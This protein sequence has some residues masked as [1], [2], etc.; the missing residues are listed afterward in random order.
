MPPLTL[1]TQ[2]LAVF[3]FF[4]YVFLSLLLLFIYLSSRS[5]STRPVPSEQERFCANGAPVVV[6]LATVPRSGNTWTRALFEHA[7]GILTE[8]LFAPAGQE[9]VHPIYGTTGPDCD[10]LKG[11]PSS[12]ESRGLRRAGTD[13]P[14]LIKDHYPFLPWAYNNTEHPPTFYLHSIRNPV[15]TFGA[16]NA[17]L[18]KLGLPGMQSFEIFV[19]RW[20]DFFDYWANKTAAP[21]QH[22]FRYEDLVNNTQQTLSTLLDVTCFAKKLSLSQ[23]DVARAVQ[24]KPAQP[25]KQ[26]QYLPAVKNVTQGLEW[27]F[28][29]HQGLLEQYG[30]ASVL[31]PLLPRR[32]NVG[33]ARVTATNNQ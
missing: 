9:S 8:I 10:A 18:R 22:V 29:H 5:V 27:L 23:E 7:S 15:D 32:V 16:I 4:S 30:Y 31:E 33:A 21:P 12:C 11:E 2:S 17:Y 3:L 28:A 20:A 6:I 24:A 1:P 14:V 25:H 19:R 26:L 13:D